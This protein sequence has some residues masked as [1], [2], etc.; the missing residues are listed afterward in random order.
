VKPLL[1]GTV[2][3][4]AIAA[5]ASAVGLSFANDRVNAAI[6]L[7]TSLTCALVLVAGASLLARRLKLRLWLRRSVATVAAVLSVPLAI[8]V[9]LFLAWS[10]LETPD[11]QEEVNGLIC[12]GSTFGNATVSLKD[13]RTEVAVFRPGTSILERKLGTR[14]WRGHS[15]TPFTSFENECAILYAQHGG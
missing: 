15:G 7:T 11:Y 3:Y 4:I 8:I 10:S 14:S 6:A 13:E 9:G 5:F 12:R 2:A 1:L